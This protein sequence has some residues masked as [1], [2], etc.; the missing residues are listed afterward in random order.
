[1]LRVDNSS[2]QNP[3]LW[4]MVLPPEVFQMN[5]ELTKIDKLLDD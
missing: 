1:M 5:E 2:Q 4:E 3:L